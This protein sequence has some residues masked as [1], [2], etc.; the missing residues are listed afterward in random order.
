MLCLP[1]LRP[2]K[3]LGKSDLCC[4]WLY[5]VALNIPNHYWS[6]GVLFKL[7]L[8]CFL[9]GLYYV[10]VINLKAILR[11]GLK[12]VEWYRVQDHLARNHAHPFIHGDTANH[13]HNLLYIVGCVRMNP[14]YRGW[15][16]IQ[17]SLRRAQCLLI[18]SVIDNN[19]T[20]QCIKEYT[21]SR[22][23]HLFTH[24]VK[25]WFIVQ[26]TTDLTLSTNSQEN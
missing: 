4:R 14:K 17:Q 21:Y 18:T 22:Q 26:Y 13:I 8:T 25:Y 6:R 16:L 15:V 9:R 2:L 19:K 1:F 23:R 24:A 20:K 10:V 7:G 11:L 5:S 12:F 3:L